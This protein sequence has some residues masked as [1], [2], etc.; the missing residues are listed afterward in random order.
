[1]KKYEKKAKKLE[2]QR[3]TNKHE[4]THNRQKNYILNEGELIPPL[5][6]MGIFTHEGKI[7]SSMQHK[8]R[9]IN[10]YLEIINDTLTDD[11]SSLKVIDFGCGKS[12]LTFIVYYFLTEIKGLKVEMIGLDLK[13]DVINHC[14]KVAEKYGYTGLTFKTGDVQEDF[15][16]I[17]NNIDMIISLHACDTATDYA[18]FQG[19]KLNA[20][21]ILAAPC[22]QHEL[23][24]QIK[25]NNLSL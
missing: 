17:E 22:C 6:D 19:I 8:Y 3:E 11:M 15:T 20:K 7:A 14:T 1:M 24:S 18:L 5:I 12:Y 4:K 2:K 10:R 16:K 23:N 13:E 9:Q 21:I 25:S